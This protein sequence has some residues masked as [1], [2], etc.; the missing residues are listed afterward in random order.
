MVRYEN[1]VLWLGLLRLV[2]YVS[3]DLLFYLALPGGFGHFSSPLLIFCVCD[4]QP[5]AME[6]LLLLTSLNSPV[7]P[8]GEAVFVQMTGFESWHQRG[9]VEN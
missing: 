5:I 8:C 9:K 4:I 1:V 2:K 3:S 7:V 6:H